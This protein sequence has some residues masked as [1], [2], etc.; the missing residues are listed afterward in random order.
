MGSKPHT[1]GSFLWSSRGRAR[2]RAL[3]C[4]YFY[5]R[6]QNGEG[7]GSPKPLPKPLPRVESGTRATYLPRE[8]GKHNLGG[9]QIK[10]QPATVWTTTELVALRNTICH[11]TTRVPDRST[12]MGESN[13]QI[14]LQGCNKILRGKVRPLVLAALRAYHSLLAK[15]KVCCHNLRSTL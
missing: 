14:T 13:H 8:P 10:H 1:I 7:G 4:S 11:L 2:P 15:V 5:G 6:P 12:C 9:Y 3:G